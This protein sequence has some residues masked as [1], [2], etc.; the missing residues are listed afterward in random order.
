M[1]LVLNDFSKTRAP[2]K[3]KICVL[4]KVKV[5][6]IVQSMEDEL[7]IETGH[8]KVMLEFLWYG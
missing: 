3:R 2:K 5:F 7:I 4:D 1:S 8:A 6:V